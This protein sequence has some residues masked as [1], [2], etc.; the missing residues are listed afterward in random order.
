MPESTETIVQRIC[1]EASRRGASFADA[2]AVETLAD[3]VL[4]QDTRANKLFS[5]AGFGMCVR[6]LVDHCW[7]FASTDT[8]SPASAA[9]CLDEAMALARA[10]AR[11]VEERVEITTPQPFVDS[12]RSVGRMMPDEMPAA[13]KVRRVMEFEAA[14]RQAAGGKIVN[15]I[16]SYSDGRQIETLANTL[17]TRIRTET[18]RSNLVT[19]MVV[20]DGKQLQRAVE[21]RAIVG[22]PELLVDTAADEFSVLAAR[23]AVD[24][25]SAKKCPAGNFTVIFHPSITG[26]LVHEALG[27]NAEADAVWAGQSLLEGRMGR[28]LACEAVSIIDDSTI[29]GAY[30]SFRY[31]SEGT[32]SSRRVI[33]DR[34]RLVSLLHSLETASKF[35]VPPNGC[36][37]ADGYE[38][39]PIVRMSNTFMDRG[40]VPFDE[41]I[42]GIDRGIYLQDGHWGY[43]FVA[44]GQFICHAGRANMIENGRIG[45]P[46]RDVSISSMTLDT[47]QNIDAVG[48]DFEMKMPGT[49]GKDGQGAPTDTGG[50]HVRVR[51]IV[52]GGQEA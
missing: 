13:E 11:F 14:G 5:S 51:D 37:R 44:K 46:L 15:S 7:G 25:L 20:S 8:V 45:E 6:V 36:A 49:C 10:S 22:G 42:R 30:G 32:P 3:S 21:H 52:V 27:H 26:L 29:P 41:M 9:A 17:G 35:A 16:V 33:I 43:V 39:K 23:K 18:C 47:L 1:D 31:D 19:Q 24:L 48:D 28:Q 4:V 50:P 2:R 12:V 40:T 34:G 38:S